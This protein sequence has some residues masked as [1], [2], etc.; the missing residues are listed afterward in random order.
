M[1]YETIDFDSGDGVATIKLDR[2]EKLNAFNRKTGEELDEVL[3]EVATNDDIRVVVFTGAGGNFSSG[4][5]HEMIQDMEQEK[6]ARFRWEY[7]RLHTLYDTIEHIE[8]PFIAAVDG[9]CTGGG[10]EIALYCDLIVATDE[11]VFG[12]PEKNIGVIP[13][14]GG[15]VKLT[16]EVGTFRAKEFVMLTAGRDQLIQAEEVMDRFGFVNRVWDGDEFDERLDELTQE[17][18]NSAPLALGLAKKIIN[19]SH[20]MDPI[21]GRR[22]E[23]TAQT[24]LMRSKDHKEG[25]EAFRE[26]R[27]PQFSG[28]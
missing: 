4:A 14:S 19:G 18:A 20:E 11:A 28:E 3:E 16:K 22:F 13:A 12:Y 9:I 2:P 26:K 15:C 25:I 6:D 5:D 27:D 1:G 23:R 24:G 7:R 8:K 21:T 17:L 10:L